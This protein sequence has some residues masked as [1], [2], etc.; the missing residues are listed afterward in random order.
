MALARVQGVARIRFI[1]MLAFHLA[2]MSHTISPVI[3]LIRSR[4]RCWSTF[5][6]LAY[7]VVAR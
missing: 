1:L 2:N 5:T 7:E 6:Q 4:V 3:L